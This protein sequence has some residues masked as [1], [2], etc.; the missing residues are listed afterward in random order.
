M[1]YSKTLQKAEETVS[2][3]CG[4]S[5]TEGKLE[6]ILLQINN[7]KRWMTNHAKTLYLSKQELLESLSEITRIQLLATAYKLYYKIHLSKVKVKLEEK[8][9]RSFH[10]VIKILLT[11]KLTQE[12]ENACRDI[13]KKVEKEL[14]SGGLG[15]RN[16]ERLQIVSAMGLSKGHWFKCPK[17]HVYAIGDCGGATTESTCPECGSKIGGQSHRLRDDNAFA[18]EMDN[19]PH[20]AW[21]EQANMENY[22]F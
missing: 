7:L 10:A 20:P 11:K 5:S 1:K 15:I 13:L 9:D 18:P 22:R 4:R 17:G 12:L 8:L 14:P 2:K 3:Y 16:E 21:S 6:Q 19:A